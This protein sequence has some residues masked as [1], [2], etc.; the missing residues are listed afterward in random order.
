MNREQRRA[1]RF[2]RRAQWSRDQAFAEPA[3][4]LNRITLAQTYTA[5]DFARL[6]NDA[7]LSW[8]RLASG[9]GTDTDFQTLGGMLNVASIIAER[10]DPLVL[11]AIERGQ[12]A[13]ATM[14]ARHAR[15]GRWGTDAQ[16]LQHMPDALDVL[17]EIIRNSTPLQMT[18]ALRE[19]IKRERE[20]NVYQ[21][22][23]TQG[24]TP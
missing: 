5:H 4:A 11:D 22:N 12:I 15:L 24:A 7:R 23:Y 10:I 2:K 21:A 8:H 6:S 13:L 16:G 1:A 14:Q 19:A 17:D 18:A 20:G 9:Y 3:T